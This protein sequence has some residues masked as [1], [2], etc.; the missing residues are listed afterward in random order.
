MLKIVI[1]FV[2][3]GALAAPMAPQ[4]AF[5]KPVNK[6]KIP[7]HKK[8][9]PKKNSAPQ[10][11]DFEASSYRG[12]ISSMRVN[13]K[14]DIQEIFFKLAGNTRTLLIK[15]CGA[16]S[17]EQPLLNWAFTEKRLISIHTDNS[18]C[19]SAMSIKR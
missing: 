10:P 7:A 11:T 16:K 6:G 12:T 1:G 18:Q 8:P 9:T 15:G 19:F 13:R 3:S 14:G 5:P 2:L 4:K 17:A